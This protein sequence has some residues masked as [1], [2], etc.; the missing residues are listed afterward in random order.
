MNITF[1]SV[2]ELK[3]K[4]RN[5]E[6]LKIKQFDG[7]EKTVILPVR[8]MVGTLYAG[9]DRYVVC[10][11]VVW[12]NKKVGLVRIFDITEDNKDKYVYEKDGVEYLTDEAFNKFVHGIDTLPYSLRKNGTWHTVGS[13]TEPG[14]CSVTFG[15]AYPYLDPNF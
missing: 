12:S 2:Q 8:G 10:C 6:T 9:S 14:C 4:Y 5:M 3:L 11:N 1:S 7:S 15:H 13:K